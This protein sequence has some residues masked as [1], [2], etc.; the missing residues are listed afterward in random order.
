[1]RLSISLVATNLPGLS[2]GVF[3]RSARYRASGTVG[4]D[5][6]FALPPVF[7]L[8]DFFLGDFFLGLAVPTVFFFELGFVV[9][10]VW[11]WCGV[12]W[13]G[14]VWCGVV[15]FGVVWCGLVWFGVV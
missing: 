8:G 3:L 12:V 2:S 15:W 9:L 10:G 14:V 4:P 6:V 7:A 1:M 5:R 13:C 11:S